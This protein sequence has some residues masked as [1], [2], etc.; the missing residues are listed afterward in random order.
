MRPRSSYLQCIIY[1]SVALLCIASGKA[2]ASAQQTLTE[3]LGHRNWEEVE[4]GYFIATELIHQGSSNIV[5]DIFAEFD[6]QYVRFEGNCEA[7]T[8][9]ELRIGGFV[10][11]TGSSVTYVDIPSDQR[12]LY[13]AS[14][15][16]PHHT[17]LRTACEKR[18]PQT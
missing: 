8:L 16:Q 17:Y 9:Q 18:K 10:G 1:T 3:D 12:H 13:D 7:M 2:K 6:L 4:P 14:E 5:F 15:G 11:S